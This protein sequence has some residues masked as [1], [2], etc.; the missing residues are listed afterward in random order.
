MSIT[1][2]P[3]QEKAK[4]A[5]LA[6]WAAG[7]S[8]VALSMGVGTGKCIAHGEPIF[9]ANGEVVL[10]ESL[11]GKTVDVI[12][13]T[14]TESM[15]QV[16]VSAT[17]SDNGE[18]E[19]YDIHLDNGVV[20]RR[21]SE[22]P[23]WAYTYET[24]VAQWVAVSRLS[25]CTPSRD[26][27]LVLT[28]RFDMKERDMYQWR[29]VVKVIKCDSPEPTVSITVHSDNHAYVGLA[30]E[31]NT[32][33]F[34]G[35]LAAER[36]RCLE[37]GEPFRALVLAH[38][39][40]LVEQPKERAAENW[41]GKLPPF[42]LVQGKNNQI[43]RQV[44]VATFQT[45]AARRV[46][47]PFPVFNDDG[48]MVMVQA[49]SDHDMPFTDF[50]GKQIVVRKYKSSRGTGPSDFGLFYQHG[51]PVCCDVFTPATLGNYNPRYEGRA[52]TAEQI[53]FGL[54]GYSYADTDNPVM[55]PQTKRHPLKKFNRLR[56][57]LEHGMFTHLVLDEC[58]HMAAPVFFELFRCLRILNPN[59]RILG[60]SATLLRPDGKPLLDVFEKV[61]YRVSTWEAIYIHKCNVPFTPYAVGLPTED[62]KELIDK[63]HGEDFTKGELQELGEIMSVPNA[64]SLIISKWEELAGDRPTMVYAGSVNQAQ[65]VC[66]AFCSAGYKAATANGKTPKAEREGT[67]ERF[68]NGELQVLV[69][70]GL[71]LEGLDVPQIACVLLVRLVKHI[72]QL[73]QML[74]RG[75]RRYPNKSDCILIECFPQGA[76]DMRMPQQL[77]GTPQ[78]QREAVKS[79]IDELEGEDVELDVI[80]ELEQLQQ[81]LL[82]ESID[83]DFEFS[84]D[85]VITQVMDFFQTSKLEWTVADDIAT[86]TVAS[87]HAVAIVMPQQ[88]RIESARELINSDQWDEAWNDML[89]SIKSYRVISIN[90]SV[91]EIGQFGDWETA[92]K[93]A[94]VYADEN[95]DRR[96]AH[97]SERWRS[98]RPSDRQINFA[99]RLGI[100]DPGGMTRGELSAAITHK[101]AVEQLVKAKVIK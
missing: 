92:S 25:E 91:N 47:K 10:V 36:A 57:V 56:K 18:R 96:L 11:I 55:V 4:Q 50:T 28:P 3:Y 20:L 70:C 17:F 98:G 24:D 68:R 46:D 79:A 13:V 101:K 8:S 88:K 99:K 95:K 54:L 81:A 64:L 30:V 52:V 85:D 35:I 71:W 80:N 45:L 78:E 5:V 43:D 63:S 51:D 82:K 39:K 72:S 77:L 93:V 94:S 6:D 42:G 89:D 97:G 21:T 26:G 41:R 44:I 37:S 2:R 60:V 73:Q 83:G 22:H 14:D 19:I 12:G 7:K 90:G 87:N 74:G 29:D 9:L 34:L 53:D 31:H 65:A 16:P 1:L 75:L 84:A 67:V 66:D 48:S 49:T 76:R 69:C 59:I 38:Q 32:E 58:H 61:S 100:D 86:A 23:V 40:E 62:A 27:H 33:T 15:K